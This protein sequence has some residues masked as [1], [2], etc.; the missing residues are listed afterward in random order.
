[1]TAR[2]LALTVWWDLDPT[3]P[4]TEVEFEELIEE[5]NGLFNL[6]ENTLSEKMS[7]SASLESVAA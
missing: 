5:L 2:N 4:P 3:V 6:S 7:R 1:M